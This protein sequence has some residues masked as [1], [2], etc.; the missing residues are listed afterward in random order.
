MSAPTYTVHYHPPKYPDR[1]F[2]SRCRHE[3]QFI[4]QQAVHIVPRKRGGNSI[5]IDHSVCFACGLPQP[6]TIGGN[7]LVD[8]TMLW[9]RFGFHAEIG[10]RVQELRDKWARIAT[11][12][13]GPEGWNGRHERIARLIDPSLTM[14]LK[15]HRY[16]GRSRRITR[17]VTRMGVISFDRKYLRE[18]AA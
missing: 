13:F 7:V 2:P 15:L 12:L 17:G 1:C 10:G 4:M 18:T 8:L 11:Y 9:G 6:C 3:P 14:K 5:E 16:R